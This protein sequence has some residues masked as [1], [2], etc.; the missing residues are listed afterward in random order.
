MVIRL[1]TAHA[2]AIRKHGEKSFPNECCG[3]IL[4]RFDNGYAGDREVTDL[5]PAENVR[6][7]DAQHNRFLIAPEE[8]LKVERLARKLGVDVIGYYHSHPD[9]P[10]RPS[11]YDREHAWPTYSYIIVS[12]M[13]GAAAAMTSWRLKDDRSAYDEEAIVQRNGN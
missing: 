1:T 7:A 4:G 3:F 11:E 5:I 6:E 13:G 9:H 10:A 12:V 8:Q 2:D